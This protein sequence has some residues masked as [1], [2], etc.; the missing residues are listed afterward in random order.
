MVEH[1]P[2][3][4]KSTCIRIGPHFNANCC[5][6]V[7]R[8]GRE[9]AWTNF[10][11]YLGI[12][13]E[14]ALRFKC[15]LD[16]ANRSFYQSFNGIFGRVGRID[17]NELIVQLVKS[18]CFPVL[19]YG[20][21]VCSLRKYQY[22]SINYVINS[23]FRKI[24]NTISQKTVDVCLEMFGCLQAERTIAIRKRKFLNKFSIIHNALCRVFV[25]TDSKIRTWGKRSKRSKR[26]VQHIHWR[27]NA[28]TV[29]PGGTL[30]D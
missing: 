5:N 7:T 13:I 16:N 29:R 3:C 19:F 9:L 20:L 30:A 2:E 28:R 10:V 11:R 17:S 23:T 12:F 21:E 27:N 1:V 6:T 26:S 18:K 8:G 14:S 24:F 4:K 25:V 22:K 15:P